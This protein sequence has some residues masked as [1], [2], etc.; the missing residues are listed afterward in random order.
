VAAPPSC[1]RFAQWIGG[2]GLAKSKIRAHSRGSVSKNSPTKNGLSRQSRS[3]GSSY[4]EALPKDFREFLLSLIEH[5]VKFLLVGGHAVALH[6]APRAT[7]DLDV[8]VATTKSNLES[9]SQALSEFGFPAASRAAAYLER[10]GQEFLLQRPG[11]PESSLKDE[12]FHSRFW[13]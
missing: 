13:A 5:K 4:L 12:S 6:G 7:F 2:F 10:R 9:L 8:V 11:A 3:Q 1:Y